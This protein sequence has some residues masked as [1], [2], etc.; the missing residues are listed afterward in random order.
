[1]RS[2]AQRVARSP[3]GRRAEHLHELAVAAAAGGRFVAA[4][5]LSRRGLEAAGEGSEVRARILLTYAWA[6]AEQAH[7]DL[8]LGLLDQAEAAARAHPR[9]AGLTRGQR[10]VLLLRLGQAQRARKELGRA[11]SLLEDEP[12]E[13]ARALLN[14]GVAELECHDFAGARDSFERC[15]Q[16]AVRFRTGAVQDRSMPRC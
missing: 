16:I 15:R 4:S 12:L 14:R 7:V 5:R 10:G 2:S 8:S 9:I 13:Q 1:V 11:V 3:G 6:E